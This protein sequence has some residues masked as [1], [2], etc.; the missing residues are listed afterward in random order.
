VAGAAAGAG[1]LWR[2]QGQLAMSRPFN[3]WTF[4]HMSALLPTDTVS[5]AAT[6][7]PLPRRPRPLEV[8]YEYEGRSRTLDELHRRTFTTGFAVLHR[9]ELVHESYPG[10]F[11]AP[12]ARFQLFSVTK[13]VTSLLTGIALDEG[14]LDSLDRTAVSLV[15][16][17]A[18][19]AY[20]G[21]TIADLLDMGSGAEGVEDYADPDAPIGRFERAVTNGGSILDVIRALPRGAAPGTVFNYSTLDTQVLGW[22]LEAATGMPLARYA[23]ERLWQPMGAEHDAYYFLTRARPRSALGGGSFNAS[24][25]DLVRLGALLAA[26]GK[27]DGRQIVPAEWIER[28]RGS[29]RDHL[30]P[31]ALGGDWPDCYGYA[32][33]WWS[34]AGPHRA[35]TGRGIYG[36]YLWVDPAADVV[37]VKTSAW[38]DADDDALAAETYA[39]FNALVAWLDVR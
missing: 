24:V 39:A 21:P 36:Q 2:N 32:N 38:P 14:S 30:K 4:T 23:T 34:L 17:L 9:G 5:R 15:P 19:S 25:R 16:E 13:S 31:G 27:R 18:G 33:Q 7:H 12:D 10:R 28:G 29:E 1:W 11:A 22:A 6:P 26:G 8:R 35:F 37:I 20:D 3:E